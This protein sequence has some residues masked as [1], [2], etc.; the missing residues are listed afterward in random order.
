VFAVGAALGKLAYDA[1]GT[2]NKADLQIDKERAQTRIDGEAEIDCEI[3]VDGET[4][5]KLEK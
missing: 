3:E 4:Y 1:F 2:S 5:I